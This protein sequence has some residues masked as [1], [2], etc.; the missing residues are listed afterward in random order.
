MD[1]FSVESFE[2]Y[3][4]GIRSK[5]TAVKYA[6]AAERFLEYC[7]SAGFSLDRLPPGA[8]NGF[9]S[10]L[11]RS[12]AAPRSVHVYV[13]GA[14][15]YL[16]WCRGQGEMIPALA[17]GDL[18]KVSMGGSPNALRDEVLVRYLSL[19]SRLAEPVRTCL[20][21]LPYCGLRSE[22]MATLS[23]RSIRKV[24]LQLRGGGTQDHIVFAV[25]GKG[26][27]VRVVPLLLDGPPLLAAY[28]Q[29]WRKQYGSRGEWLFPMRGG[30]APIATRTLRYYVQKIREVMGPDGTKKLTPHT[31]RRTYLTTLWRAGLDVPTLTKIA[32]HKSVQTTMT[33]YLDIQPEDLASSIQRVGA[34]LVQSASATQSVA[35]RVSGVLR[36][37]AANRNGG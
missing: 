2:Q 22:E 9:S 34:R 25:R 12:G 28:L 7:V 16:D 4:L 24:A 31:L 15:R 33:H 6:Q 20:L 10:W 21:L 29:G 26:G 23:V 1:G 17:K 27:D 3:L 8:M 11:T 13:A 19:A 35:S 37:T 32:G 5:N 18:P 36:D 30:S 14:R